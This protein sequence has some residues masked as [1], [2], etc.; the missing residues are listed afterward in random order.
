MLRR[1]SFCLY[2]TEDCSI[3]DASTTVQ[4]RQHLLC[5]ILA[6]LTAACVDL[7]SK[8]SQVGVE[9]AVLY[10]LLMDYTHQA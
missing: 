1:G 8:C 3:N 10:M 2:C 5:T 7:S 9:C 4:V 6:V